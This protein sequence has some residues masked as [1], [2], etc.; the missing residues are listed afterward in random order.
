M[1]FRM[2]ILPRHK[3]SR[4]ETFQYC[5][6]QGVLGTGWIVEGLESTEIW[7]TYKSA[8]I[9]LSNKDGDPNHF[10]NSYQSSKYLYNNIKPG[11]LIWTRNENG[12]YFLARVTKGWGYLSTD[13]GI[14]LDIA[15]IVY[16]DI[17]KVPSVD[18]VPGKVV[19]SF[20]A[21]R[22]TQR[23]G[24][25]KSEEFKVVEQYSRMLWNKLS[26]TNQYEIDSLVNSDFFSLISDRDAEDLVCIYLQVQGWVYVP[27]SRSLDTMKYEYY[28]VN[29]TSKKRAIVQV[30]T[31]KSRIDVD[32]LN[33]FHENVFVFQPNNHYDGAPGAECRICRSEIIKFVEDYKS[34][35]P[36][37]ILNWYELIG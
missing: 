4:K 1:A 5:L 35:I 20:R 14:K 21:T 10:D 8:A 33:N 3:N 19:S 13:Q 18:D 12:Q 29:L 28:F 24:M 32:S 34:L 23:I 31:G 37:N 25:R 16:C 27:G 6:E 36:N 30:K 2:H 15:S 26:K 7:E 9:D 17:K 22:T 11:D